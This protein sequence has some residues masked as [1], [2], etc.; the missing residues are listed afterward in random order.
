M[1][2]W[3]LLVSGGWTM[4]PLLVCSILGLAIVIEKSIV[5]R[6]KRVI[7]ESIVEAINHNPIDINRI[8]NLCNRYPSPFSAIIKTVLENR[9]FQKGANE[10]NTQLEGKV[11]VNRMERGL[12]VLEV[13]AAVSPLLGLLGTVLGLVDVFFVVA[14]M[15]VGQTGAFANGIAKALI[16]TVVGLFIAIPSLICYRYFSKKVEDLVLVMEKEASSLIN[17]IY[18]I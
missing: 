10:E 8:S 6:T 11:Q 7:P 17:R 5:L 9:S 14:K 18:G 13:I 16:T 2:T 15:G 1:T 4:I 3:Q 12:V